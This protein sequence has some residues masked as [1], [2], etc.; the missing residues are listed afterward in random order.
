MYYMDVTYI[1]KKGLPSTW[2][3]QWHLVI[4]MHLSHSLS[5]PVQEGVQ[6]ELEYK[7]K[8]IDEFE[9]FSPLITQEKEAL[10]FLAALSTRPT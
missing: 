7:I 9:T 1:P 4:Y 2:S 8:R 3:S 5:E 6:S 10:L